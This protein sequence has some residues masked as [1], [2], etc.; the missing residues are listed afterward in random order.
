MTERSIRAR[1]VGGVECSALR[2]EEGRIK[3]DGK[4]HSSAAD[5]KNR[6]GR[7]PFMARDCIEG[8]QLSMVQAI[9]RELSVQGQL[10]SSVSEGVAWQIGMVRYG[11]QQ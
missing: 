2:S 5:S 9:G 8:W 6:Q 3:I 4:A 1:L 10:Q 7:A 11:G